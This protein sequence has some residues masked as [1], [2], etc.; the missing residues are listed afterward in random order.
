MRET[1]GASSKRKRMGSP[2]ADSQT[3]E[4][5]TADI[6]SEH[7]SKQAES[8]KLG[9]AKE[10][11]CLRDDFLLKI[12]EV[13]SN[14][15]KRFDGINKTVTN[16]IDRVNQLEENF[17]KS[18]QHQQAEITTLQK[19]C[20]DLQ[21][22]EVSCDAILFGIPALP[23]ENLTN[24]FNTLCHTIKC[25]PP[26]LTNIFRTKKSNNNSSTS[27]IV[28][29]FCNSYERNT[30][31]MSA[32]NHRK[33]HG[34]ELRLPDFGI[35]SVSISTHRCFLNENLTKQTRFLLNSALSLKRKKQLIGVHTKQG[36][37]YVKNTPNGKSFLIESSQD[38]LAAAAATATH[39]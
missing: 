15:S 17:N 4:F 31:L 3:N 35:D 29:K 28:I 14:W 12:E 5:L 25:K 33:Q 13:S 18:T 11:S 24:L 34:T 10:I 39:L 26:P 6:L 37:V 27:P 23:D 2:S 1:R 16:L 38:L 22:K 20:R 21:K 8:I 19:Q 7:P 30:V 9:F 32:A 36:N